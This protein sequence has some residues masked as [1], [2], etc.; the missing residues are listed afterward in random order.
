MGFV[1]CEGRSRETQVVLF[2]S[3]KTI[4]RI[5]L[6][7]MSCWAT[8]VLSTASKGAVVMNLDSIEQPTGFLDVD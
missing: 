4:F 6:S 7:S 3:R 1:F 8:F 2:A 5:T